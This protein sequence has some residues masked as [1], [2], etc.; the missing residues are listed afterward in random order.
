MKKAS[1]VLP[2]CIDLTC[3]PG[4]QN[5][6]RLANA[7]RDTCPDKK[8]LRLFEIINNKKIILKTALKHN[9]LV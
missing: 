5:N 4:Y 8:V 9:D 3:S 1:T 2:I 6:L 7:P